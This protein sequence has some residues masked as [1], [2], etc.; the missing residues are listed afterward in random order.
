M[1]VFREGLEAVLILAV[2][3]AGMVG[4][5]RRLRRP[6]F[7]GAAGRA[8]RDAPSPGRS[9]RRILTSLSRYG[10]KLEAVVS[11]VAIAILLLILNWFF[12]K[13]YWTEPPGRP[14]PEE[15]RA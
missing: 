8:G 12:H 9:R 4:V 7:I 2:L 11:L 3:T 6:M 10:E 1:I 14:A 15:A 5:Q 13:V